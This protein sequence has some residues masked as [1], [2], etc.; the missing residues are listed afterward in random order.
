M[1]NELDRR[2]S[3]LPAADTPTPAKAASPRQNEAPAFS[4]RHENLEFDEVGVGRSLSHEPQGMAVARAR[5]DALSKAMIGG[6]DVFYGFSDFSSEIGR[7]R[8]ESVAK[9]L[10]TSNKGL[11]T[12]HS[13]GSPEC[14][15]KDLT[16]TCRL[17]VRGTISFRGAIDPSYLLLDQ[18]S[19]KSLGLDRRQYYDGEPVK[20]SLTATKDSYIYLFSWDAED[21]LYL[22]FPSAHSKNN[23]LQAGSP[24]LLPQEDSGLNYR[25]TLPSGKTS[26][27]EKLLI[28]AAQKELTMPNIPGGGG[29][30]AYKAGTMT[31]VM[32]D[33]A[34]LERREW[35]LQVIPYDILA[36]GAQE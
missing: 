11:L 5:E 14:A 35:T 22:V 26:A 15:I 28:I 12:E 2:T 23:F 16:T 17:R 20:I 1:L 6:A 29:L 7:V 21:D 8:H 24:L 4:G 3:P 13:A 31:T 32:R 34:Q 19:G 27:A 10:F 9:Y 18:Q 36:R 30:S 33:L 25:A